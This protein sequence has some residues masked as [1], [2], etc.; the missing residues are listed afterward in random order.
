MKRLSILTGATGV[1]YC[2]A[3]LATPVD[4]HVRGKIVSV[5]PDT[6]V[7]RTSSGENVSLSLNGGTHYLRVVPSSLDQIGPDSY[8]GHG[9]QG[10]WVC[11]SRTGSD[12]LPGG[13]ARHQS[14]SLPLRQAARHD[15]L[16]RD[17]NL[18]HDDQR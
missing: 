10:H 5:S 15:S 6:L 18:E 1:L 14:G 11:A 12:D 16:G 13:D 3:L 17:D 9:D 7:V 2:T 4:E 8:I